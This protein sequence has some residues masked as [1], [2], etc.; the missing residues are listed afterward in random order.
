MKDI[1]RKLVGIAIAGCLLSSVT[2]VS[3]KE[4][5]IS[6][7]VNNHA[8]IETIDSYVLN[9]GTFVEE[10]T[11]SSKGTIEENIEKAFSG[12]DLSVL[13][14][15]IL[16]ES[17]A[18]FQRE[19]ILQKTGTVKRK[20]IDR[21]NIDRKDTAR[22]VSFM[23]LYSGLSKAA[24]A[25]RHI[26]SLSEVQR[27]S[28]RNFKK[29]G[30]LPLAVSVV[31]FESIDDKAFEDGRL[32]SR[33]GRL[34]DA[35]KGSYWQSHTFIDAGMVSFESEMDN[36]HQMVIPSDMF[37]TNVNVRGKPL[38]LRSATVRFK[39]TDSKIKVKPDQ[40][41]T[42]PLD[43]ILNDKS[44]LDMSITVNTN[45]G[46]YSIRSEVFFDINSK[47]FF[48]LNAE[49][50]TSPKPI[51]KPFTSDRPLPS[52][53][54]FSPRPLPVSTVG[55]ANT[56]GDHMPHCDLEQTVATQHYLN[57]K[58]RLNVRVYPA[59]SDVSEC[60]NLNRVLILVDGFD[61]LNNRTQESMLP[62]F[63]GAIAYFI[64]LG[65]DVITVDY[66][67]GNDYIQR[68]GQ[69]FR[70]LMVETV[71]S[72]MS[73]M[74]DTTDVAIIAG[75]MGGQVVNYGLR[76]AELNSEDHNARLFMTLDTEY[77]GGNIPI[78]LQYEIGFLGEFS[79]LAS[80]LPSFIY[81]SNSDGLD[82]MIA[83]LDSPAARQLLRH[84]YNSPTG[85]Y[86]SHPLYDAFRGEMIFL[87]LP[88]MT[89]NV[90]IANGSGTGDVFASTKKLLSSVN[91]IGLLSIVL[92]AYTDHAGPIFDGVVM[93]GELELLEKHKWIGA[94]AMHDDVRPGSARGTPQELA[95]EYNK[96]DPSMM[97]TMGYQ[98]GKHNFVP[99]ESATAPGFDYSYHEKCNSGHATLTVGNMEVFAK[100]LIAMKNGVQPVQAP[101]YSQSCG[102]PEPVACSQNVMWWDHSFKSPTVTGASCRVENV[103]Y[104]DN[105]Y[106]VGQ[107]YYVE[108]AQACPSPWHVDPATGRCRISK[109]TPGTIYNNITGTLSVYVS[110]QGYGQPSCPLNT[111]LLSTTYP[112]NYTGPP[113]LDYH[114]VCGVYSWMAPPP[115][116]MEATSDGLFLKQG[117]LCPTGG[118]LRY[119]GCYMGEAPAGTTPT[120]SGNQ[121]RYIE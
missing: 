39:G 93:L 48:E 86:A 117:D 102:Q 35:G 85:S 21:K 116:D 87:G 14:S 113:I 57:E 5:A 99:T 55:G 37:L 22:P 115:G 30:A 1:N 120:I 91:K 79:D 90:S 110:D 77:Q 76:H 19:E 67:V 49:P 89:R 81:S 38:S 78:G 109:L 6:K 32:I 18:L 97:G 70:T 7:Q 63:G 73:Y 114:I 83:A 25:G 54:G 26:P 98:L 33:E 100:E 2:A 80:Q 17:G 121:Y 84:H 75:S 29:H 88:Q 50:G 4:L 41:F 103:Q 71:P 44:T 9:D 96:A 119:D 10:R 23:N 46:K 112:T 40:P 16:L 60:K 42:V 56:K 101:A 3:A 92:K 105:A 82:K 104:G 95:E 13:P 36:I 47:I 52:K 68:N 15:K 118:D 111:Q 106:T 62:E 72:L 94:G 64:S 43:A 61:V 31:D 24:E 69:A 59:S 65:Y 58:G 28:I 34:H 45:G 66:E 11:V 20:N 8:T 108:K 12:L 74:P 53:P 51:L 107:E 27:K